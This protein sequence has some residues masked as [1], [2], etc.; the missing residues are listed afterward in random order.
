MG[1]LAS[2]MTFNSS[3]FTW[4]P[5]FED[6]LTCLDVSSVIPLMRFPSLEVEDSFA[7][8]GWES[9]D[10]RLGRA[11]RV[12]STTSL[13]LAAKSR[14]RQR[15]VFLHNKLKESPVHPGR[16]IWHKGGGSCLLN[17]RKAQK[18][19]IISPPV[20][21]CFDSADWARFDGVTSA[22]ASESYAAFTTSRKSDKN[23]LRVVKNETKGVELGN[24]R[25][26]FFLSLL[27]HMT[28]NTTPSKAYLHIYRNIQ[29]KK[30]PGVSHFCSVHK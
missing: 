18:R 19:T 15:A 22:C 10:R 5:I 7:D 13:I 28:H 2:Y 3:S 20:G 23:E 11:V 27:P 16:S 21:H 8:P 30:C 1:R 29:K 17:T 24:F 14:A 12:F 6:R 9:K 26:F 4:A 25:Q